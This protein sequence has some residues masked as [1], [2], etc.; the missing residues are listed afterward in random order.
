[1]EP[2]RTAPEFYPASPGLKMLH[3]LSEPPHKPSTRQKLVFQT[4]LKKEPNGQ[5]FLL[6]HAGQKSSRPKAR[7]H[8]RLG[9]KLSTGRKFAFGQF[10]PSQESEKGRETAAIK[11][12]SLRERS[13]I[14]T[15]RA[16]PKS[17]VGPCRKKRRP[18]EHHPWRGSSCNIFYHRKER[19]E[20]SQKNPGMHLHK[21]FSQPETS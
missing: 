2:R 15:Q 14:S 7:P 19:R 16:C 5:N 11:E 6:K 18:S 4:R 17:N 3:P 10:F 8:P 12:S 21:T 13:Q 1:M 20:I 9:E